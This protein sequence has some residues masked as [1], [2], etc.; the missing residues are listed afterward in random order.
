MT[1]DEMIQALTDAKKDLGGD[2]EFRLH[3]NCNGYG[4]Y[5]TVSDLVYSKIFGLRCDVSTP[6]WA[7]KNLKNNT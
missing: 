5:L 1:I 4:D 2:E 6:W 3:V 7:Y